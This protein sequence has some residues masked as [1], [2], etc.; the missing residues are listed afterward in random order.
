ML[1]QVTAGAESSRLLDAVFITDPVLAGWESSG[2]YPSG[3][4]GFDG[5]WVRTGDRPCLCVRKGLWT[6][7]RVPVTPLAY[8]RLR[9]I[10]RAARGG[11]YAFRFFAADGKELASDEYNSIDASADWQTREVFTQAR[12]DAVAMRVAFVADAGDLRIAEATIT[13]ASPTEVLAGN[14]ALYATLPPVR[15]LLAPDRL[16]NLAAP[17]AVLQQGGALRVLVLGDSIANDMSNAQFHLLI[18]RQYP[19]SQITLL[20]SFGSG[21][22]C[23]YYQFHVRECV[24]DKQPDLV[25]IAGIS[26]QGNAVAVRN[27]IETTR[28]LCGRPVAFLVLTG[29]IMQPGANNRMRPDGTLI[30]A[31]E[32][33]RLATEQERRFL[34]ELEAMRDDVGFAVFDM[35]TAWEEYLVASGRPRAWFQRDII[36]ANGRGKQILGRIME[37]FFAPVKP[38]K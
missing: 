23:A 26:H 11:Y 9:F 12:E 10:A 21:T 30:S 27:V 38:R 31:E 1:M 28:R 36:H 29:A 18:Q 34:V 3:E 7:P 32:A 5:E 6:S 22:G 35:R 14:D 4:G 25:I 20:R 15:T 19:G 17:C 24:V 8:Y 16:R 2:A 37:Q 33:F 13:N